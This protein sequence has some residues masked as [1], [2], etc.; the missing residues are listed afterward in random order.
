MKNQV[1]HPIPNAAVRPSITLRDENETF[2]FT[3]LFLSCL[4][5]ADICCRVTLYQA[6]Y[7][8]MQ[9]LSAQSNPHW[10]PVASFTGEEAQSTAGVQSS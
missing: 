5:D 1:I 6:L 4:A 2:R 8:F 7:G 10:C 3:F 9:H